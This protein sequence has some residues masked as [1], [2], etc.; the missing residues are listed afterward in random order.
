MLK[1]ALLTLVAG[2]VLSSL[3]GLAEGSSSVR[4]GGGVLIAVGVIALVALAI[5]KRPESVVAL[6]NEEM[7]NSEIP[8]GVYQ[9]EQDLRRKDRGEERIKK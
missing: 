6:A 3:A 8:R 9:L 4:W 2:L 7:P 1:A 5:W